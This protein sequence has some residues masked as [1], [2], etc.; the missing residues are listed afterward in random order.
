MW[1]LDLAIMKKSQETPNNCH[2]FCPMTQ[3]ILES[4][5]L[6]EKTLPNMNHYA[7][8]LLKSNDK[9]Y[10]FINKSPTESCLPCNTILK[11]AVAQ[12]KAGVLE[13]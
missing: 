7:I 13:D 9:K 6:R 8:L 3:N 4:V 2:D 12:G 5:I 10:V 1:I 11:D